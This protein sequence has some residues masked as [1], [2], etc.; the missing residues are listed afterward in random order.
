MSRHIL[1]QNFWNVGFDGDKSIAEEDLG[2]SKTIQ[3]DAQ[4]DN[5]EMIFRYV[6]EIVG[7]NILFYWLKD[8]NW[9]TIETEKSPI[10]VRR[11]YT[12]PNWDGKYEYLKAGK[13]GFPQTCS[14]G[15]VLAT[16]DAPIE[17]WNNLK[18][19]NEP[20]GEILKNSV[21]SDLD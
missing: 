20:I 15:E 5:P 12:N 18:I 8:R 17:I 16:F 10:E 7:L 19:D 13:E 2:W 4:T 21:I 14:E 11:I 1:I 9:Y 6:V 3:E